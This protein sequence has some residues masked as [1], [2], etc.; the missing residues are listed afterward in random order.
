MLPKYQTTDRNLLIIDFE[1]QATT[2]LYNELKNYIIS[3]GKKSKTMGDLPTEW[4]MVDNSVYALNEKIKYVIHRE[5][6]PSEQQL[7]LYNL[8]D[9]QLADQFI[10]ITDMYGDDIAAMPCLRN[11]IDFLFEEKAKP[12]LK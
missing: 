10:M 1:N 8:K 11:I 9:M 3:E 2:D 12:I 7:E 5:N 4:F 6:N